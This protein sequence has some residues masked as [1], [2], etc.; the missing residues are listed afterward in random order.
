[1][2]ND[3][4]TI[5]GNIRRF[6]EQMGLTQE[7]LA[8]YLGTSREQVAYYESGSRTVSSAHL[9]KLSDLFCIDEYE[10]YEEDQQKIQVNLAFAFR[11]ESISAGDLAT[12]AGFKRIVKNYLNMKRVIAD[13]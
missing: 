2:A 4:Q 13:E 8:E 5:G 3:N 10:F 7:V 11:A 9:A 12:I 6:R 1:M